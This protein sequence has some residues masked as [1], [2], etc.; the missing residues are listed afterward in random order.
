MSTSSRKPKI[1]PVRAWL[2]VSVKLT[3]FC[4]LHGGQA[5]Y[6]DYDTGEVIPADR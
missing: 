6:L 5:C 4:I 3:W 2:L 1:N